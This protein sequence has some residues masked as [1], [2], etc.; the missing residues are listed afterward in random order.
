[1][2]HERSQLSGPAP[3]IRQAADRAPGTQAP[4]HA[5]LTNG[6]D[7][8]SFRRAALS[9]QASAGNRAVAASFAAIARAAS[10]AGSLSVVGSP[11]S[12]AAPPAHG[13][14]DIANSASG[15]RAAGV[16]SLPA[17]GAPDVVIGAPLQQAGGRWQATINPTSVTPDAATSLYPGAGLHDEEP[18]ATGLQVHRHV[19]PAAADEIKR[20]EE[21]HLLDLEWARHLAYDQV[22]DAVNRAAAAGPAS[23]ATSD[24]ARQAAMFQVRSA[25]PEKARWPAGTD[26]ITHWRRVYG[27]L[28]AVTRERD[29]P[30]RW[31]NISTEIVMEPAVKRQLHVPV[32]HELRRYIAGT[33]QVGQHQSDPL[34]N[35]RYQSLASEPLGTGPTSQNPFS[36]PIPPRNGPS[37]PGDFEPNPS[38]QAMAVTAGDPVAEKHSAS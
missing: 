11:T 29:Q 23:G 22:A 3:E 38:D 33:T 8:G 30:N 27:Q 19:T 7:L 21:E 9:L 20:G 34:V 1:V 26:P 10:R 6:G 14:L 36:Q 18:T 13:V 4:A 37:A 17:P 35:A 24:E 5:P 2:A 28:V 31:H 32:S 15:L 25:V 12:T 16:T